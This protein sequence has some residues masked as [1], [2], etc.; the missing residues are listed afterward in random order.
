MFV[1]ST[2]FALRDCS[3]TADIY[4]Q[5]CRGAIVCMHTRSDTIF[6]IFFIS[7]QRSI[8]DLQGLLED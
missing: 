2:I 7:K 3:V 6:V 4:S 5:T 1:F 8:V